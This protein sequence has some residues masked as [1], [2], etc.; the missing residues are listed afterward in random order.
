MQDVGGSIIAHDSSPSALPLLL[1]DLLVMGV[2][3]SF[4]NAV[5]AL[6]FQFPLQNLTCTAGAVSMAAPVP[7]RG[8]GEGHTPAW[9]SVALHRLCTMSLCPRVH[10]LTCQSSS[11][12]AASSLLLSVIHSSTCSHQPLSPYRHPRDTC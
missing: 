8:G 4:L 11:P 3:P 7:P 10:V 6:M 12:R 9:P 1:D 5:V 2:R